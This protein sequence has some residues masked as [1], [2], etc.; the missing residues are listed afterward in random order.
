[1]QEKFWYRTKRWDACDEVYYESAMSMEFD[2]LEVRESKLKELIKWA[3][4]GIEEVCH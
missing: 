4:G 3:Q 1:M 2:T